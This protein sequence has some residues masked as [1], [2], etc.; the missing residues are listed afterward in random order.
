[1]QSQP[2][3][4]LETVIDSLQADVEM[5][6]ESLLDDLY[7]FRGRLEK[8]QAAYDGSCPA[9]AE[10]VLHLLTSGLSFFYEAIECIEEFCDDPLES[11]LNKA[12]EHARRGH[13]VLTEALASQ[14]SGSLGGFYL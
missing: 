2:L 8:L 7:L 6:I 13:Q 14:P 9:G 3:I 1:M 4:Y 12:R 11:H 5:D 10:S